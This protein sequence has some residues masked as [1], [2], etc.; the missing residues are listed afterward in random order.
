MRRLGWFSPF[1]SRRRFLAKISGGLA[2]LSLAAWELAGGEAAPRDDHLHLLDFRD[3]QGRRQP[4]RSAAD[5]A[6][7]RTQ[8][9]AGMQEVF[10]PLPRFTDRVSFKIVKEVCEPEFI[11]RKIELTGGEGTVVPAYLFLPA[12]PRA[13]P[14]P[15]I[16]C[17]HQTNPHG[18]DEAAGIRG[19]PHMDYARSLARRGYVTLAPDYPS[20]GEY[21]W[22]LGQHREFVSG[23][24][25]AIADNRRGIDLL[26]MLPEVDAHRIGCV[27]HSLGGH[28]TLFT[29]AFEPRL[30]VLATSCG[31]SRFSRDDVP[32][33]TGPRYLPRIKTHY[34]NSA[35]QIPFDFPEVLGAIAPRPLFISAARQDADFDVRG[36]RECVAAAQEVYTLLGQA[37]RLVAIYPPG[38]HDFPLPVQQQVWEFFDQQL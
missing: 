36:V 30:K 27:G 35:R 28:G 21:A 17:L 37:H 38:K 25:R 11:R 34:G 10:G 31:F 4:V 26:Q 3:N 9:L 19:L 20:L 8:I 13:Q 32:S 2:S 29:A 16:L 7:R 33:W 5:W 24:M 12:T 18:K 1:P 14:G 6:R 22:E 23:S 15:A